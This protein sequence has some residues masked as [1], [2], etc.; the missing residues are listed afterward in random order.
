M[1]GIFEGWEHLIRLAFVAVVLVLA[2]FA[3][4]QVVIPAEF[5]KY[6]H[7]RPGSLDEIASGK[8]IEWISY[9]GFMASCSR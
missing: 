1:W 9:R 8:P 4:R 7:Y 3:I 6:G 2:F 5:G